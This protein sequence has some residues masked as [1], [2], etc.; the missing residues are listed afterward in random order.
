MWLLAQLIDP[1]S[2]ITKI[3]G[4]SPTQPSH[5]KWKISK[6]AYTEQKKKFA[7]IM[8]IFMVQM[9]FTFFLFFIN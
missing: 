2:D 7:S 9:I 4:S 3:T 1:V 8:F 5:N 6:G